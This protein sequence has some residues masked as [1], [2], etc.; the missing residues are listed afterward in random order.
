MT[1]FYELYGDFEWLLDYMGKMGQ[2]LTKH[3]YYTALAALSV[4]G[5]FAIEKA[6]SAI[7]DRL[8][9]SKEIKWI[10]GQ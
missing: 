7:G 3:G 1:G 4:N 10:D 5:D 9:T 8:S 6:Q 2:G